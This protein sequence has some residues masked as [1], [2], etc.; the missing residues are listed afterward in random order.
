MKIFGSLLL[1]MTATVGLSVLATVT[2]GAN[3]PSHKSAMAGIQAKV[4][5]PLY[6]PRFLESGYSKKNKRGGRPLPIGFSA[7]DSMATCMAENCSGLTGVPDTAMCQQRYC[8]SEQFSQN[9]KRDDS[10]QLIKTENVL[11]VDPNSGAGAI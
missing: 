9:Q 8:P 3:D 5:G 7:N 11:T 6:S 10:R 2:D 1:M 4:T